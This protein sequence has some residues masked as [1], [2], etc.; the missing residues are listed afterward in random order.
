M[1]IHAVS[2]LLM[3]APPLSSL[4]IE[5]GKQRLQQ[6]C[7]LCHLL[8]DLLQRDGDL[9]VPKAFEKGLQSVL[10]ECCNWFPCSQHGPR[11]RVGCGIP[12]VQCLLHCRG[13]P[14]TAGA[15]RRESGCRNVKMTTGYTGAQRALGAKERQ[16]NNS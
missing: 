4:G 14:D 6:A 9:D 7:V 3:A 8:V 16:Q 13:R 12:C 5:P 11:C 2:A 10:S 15:V 1:A